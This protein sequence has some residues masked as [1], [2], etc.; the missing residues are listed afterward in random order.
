M[1]RTSSRLLLA[2]MIAAASSLA[3][4][5]PMPGPQGGSGMDRDA[6]QRYR[7]EFHDLRMAEFK[8]LLKLAPQQEAAWSSFAAVMRPLPQPLRLTAAE[9]SQLTPQQRLERQQQRSALWQERTAQRGQAIAAF[10]AQLTPE[11]LQVF[12]QNAAQYR[13]QSAPMGGARGG[14]RGGGMRGGMRGGGMGGGMQ[15]NC[16]G[17]PGSCAR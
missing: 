1:K 10:R 13:L 5:Q 4:A 11:Q 7:I 6:I 2:V 9:F 15:G 3:L 8:A 14:M 17:V 16:G 12:D